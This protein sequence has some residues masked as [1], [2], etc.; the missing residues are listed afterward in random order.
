MSP[1]LETIECSAGKKMSLMQ[2]KERKLRASFCTT[3]DDSTQARASILLPL[4]EFT[5]SLVFRTDVM[6]KNTTQK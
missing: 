2:V 6:D 5:R 3:S 4:S 1:G